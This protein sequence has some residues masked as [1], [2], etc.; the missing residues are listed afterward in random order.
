[1]IIG[2]RVGHLIPANLE[3]F[4]FNKLVK[5]YEENGSILWRN[6]GE[7]GKNAQIYK[8]GDVCYFYYT[9]LPD[10]S[11]RILLR[12]YVV[13]SNSIYDVDKKIKGFRINKICSISLKDEYKFSLN[14]L[15]KVYNIQTLRTQRYLW[16]VKDKHLI[17]KLEENIEE[18][19]TL[20]SI[21]KYFDEEVTK[22]FFSDDNDLHPTFVTENNFKYYEIHHLVQQH[23]KRFHP[24]I[25]YILGDNRNKFSL[26]PKCHREIH[27]GKKEDVKKKIDLLY[28]YQKEWYNEKFKL[29][30]QEKGYI[31]VLD[32]IYKMYKIK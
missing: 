29:F 6:G 10:F 24:E 26:C 16:S 28:K 20:I 1:M 13:D 17:K 12:G 2:E 5:E 21:K 25:K 8:N 7:Q 3:D 14:N 4:D 15:R 22:C 19:N 32:W 18:E 11:K 9:N 23:N 31:T 27:H 30:A